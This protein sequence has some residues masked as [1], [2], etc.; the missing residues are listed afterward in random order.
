MR[1]L[2]L[3]IEEENLKGTHQILEELNSSSITNLH[4]DLRTIK[5]ES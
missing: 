5:L 4:I 1:N 3:E 2:A